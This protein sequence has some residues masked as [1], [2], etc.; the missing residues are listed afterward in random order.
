LLV[1]VFRHILPESHFIGISPKSLKVSKS[2]AKNRRMACVNGIARNM[3][4]KIPVNIFLAENPKT[5]SGG[6]QFTVCR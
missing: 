1:N 3:W 4:L 2:G 5:N 6:A